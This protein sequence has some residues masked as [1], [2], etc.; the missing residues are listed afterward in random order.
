[1]SRHLEINISSIS[2]NVSVFWSRSAPP[3]AVCPFEVDA[4]EFM[5]EIGVEIMVLKSR[6]SGG[7]LVRHMSVMESRLCTS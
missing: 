5:S 2:L 7:A 1:M 6:G 3:A 4:V